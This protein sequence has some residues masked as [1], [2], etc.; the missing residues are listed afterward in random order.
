MKGASIA[1]PDWREP[2]RLLEAQTRERAT[3]KQRDLATATRLALTG[4]EPRTIVAA[5]LEDH[6]R[7]MIHGVDTDGATER[8][9]ALLRSF[10]AAAAADAELSNR[11]ASAWID[12]HRALETIEHLRRLRPAQGDA[13]TKRSRHHVGDTLYEDVEYGV[14]SSIGADGRVYFAG[15]GGKSARPSSLEPA[16]ATSRPEDYPQFNEV[17][18]DSS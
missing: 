4:S 7:P 1:Y 11:T 9:R 14:V 6:V 5:M 13:V 15:G 12:H 16:P 3:D 8:Q 10:G 17:S 18:D 2:V